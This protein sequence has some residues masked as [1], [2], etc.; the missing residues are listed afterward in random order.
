MD[1]NYKFDKAMVKTEVDI[2]QEE[3]AKLKAKNEESYDI[4]V[5]RDIVKL[6]KKLKRAQY[7][8]INITN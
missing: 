8:E 2:L 7:L 5:S 4:N 3:I 1:V 6:K